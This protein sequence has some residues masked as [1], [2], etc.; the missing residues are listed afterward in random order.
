MAGSREKQMKPTLMFVLASLLGATAVHAQTAPDRT[1]DEIKVET[2]ARAERGAYPLIGLDPADVREA[3]ANIRTRDRDEWAAAWSEV[4][5]RYYKAAEASQSPEERRKNFLRAWRLYYFA[6][7]PVA[8]SAGKKSAYA[9][10]LDAFLRANEAISPPL[11]VIRIPFEGKEI[12]GYLRLPSSVD[13]PIPLVL[14][15]SGLDSRKENMADTYGALVGR[16]VGFFA[17][18][19]PGTGQS[20]VKASPTADRVFSRILDYLASRKEIDPKRIVVH[21]VSFGGYWASKLAITERDRLRGA[22]VQSP[23]IADFFTTHHLETS[24]LGNRE[25]LFDQVPALF[26]VM[27]GAT[28]IPELETVMPMLS[29]K[30]QGLLG[31]P[32]APMLVIAGVKDTQVPIS[33]MYLLLDNG[34][35]PKEAWIN[36]SGGHLG[37]ERG[38]WTD[39]VIFEKIIAPWEIKMLT[40]PKAA[41]ANERPTGR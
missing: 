27:E 36:P 28:S 40:E 22:V 34:D 30:T 10:A 26:D 35:V 25:Y 1:I 5:Q 2:Q 39:P 29:L 11:E 14:A 18:D 19:G 24:L 16:G 37:R 33:D 32:T 13:R 31:K 38:G 6:Q 3:L 9:K 8:A 21:G 41:G 17:V 20:P 15:I 12:V 4:A 7:W 23:P